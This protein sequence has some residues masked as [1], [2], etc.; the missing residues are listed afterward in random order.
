MPTDDGL[1]RAILGGLASVVEPRPDLEVWE[2]AEGRIVLG[3][4][5]TPWPGPL[6]FSRSPYMIGE[7]SPLWAY[8]RYEQIDNIWATQ[9]GKTLMLQVTVRYDA[10]CDPGPG[11]IVYP[12]QKVGQR[13]S[14]KHIRPFLEDASHLMTGVRDDMQNFEYRLTTCDI[15]IAW[16]GS[17]AVLAAEPI[18]H[19][20][21]DEEAKFD[22]GDDREAD[23]KSLALRRLMAYRPF[24]NSFGCTTPARATDPGWRDWEHSTQC[25]RWVPCP[26]CGA[27]QVVY[28][29][30]ED[31]GWL[32]PENRQAEFRGG[33]RWN[34]DEGLSFDDRCE[35]AYV[36]CRECGGRWDNSQLNAADDAGEWRPRRP[37]ARNYASHLPSWY[38]RTVKLADVVGRWLLG[39]RDP[40][41]RQD[42]DNSDRAIPWE[43]PSLKI[44][45]SVLER[46]KLPGHRRGIVPPAADV[47]LLTAD[48]MDDH[49]R[50]RVR[51]WNADTT[52]WGV[53][54][55]ALPPDLA[56]LHGVMARRYPRGDGMIGI[57]RGL[58]D[59]RWRTDE[60]EQYCLASG[61][62]C[63]PAMGHDNLREIWRPRKVVVVPNVEKGLLLGGELSRIDYLDDRWK[64]MMLQR[65]A[66]SFG[67]PG[68]WYIE[69]DVTEEYLHQ[70]QGE[71]KRESKDKRGR[72]H[73]AWNT[74]HANH[75]WDCEKLQ[76]LAT[77]VFQL[78]SMKARPPPAQQRQVINPYTG[79]VVA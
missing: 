63:W 49:I 73:M 53:D 41:L 46:H 56:Q 40:K 3:H 20:K 11:M 78:T 15:V 79:R 13:R 7:W 45:S 60:V 32:E 42:F 25:Q 9:S 68:C 14:K 34:K 28:F 58:I 51:A 23:S 27:Y 47:L 44:E 24:C 57:A 22:E 52:S 38:S 72:T 39:Y 18:K 59:A 36:E 29:N 75:D 12:T 2:W 35:T 16:A 71:V 5:V 43:A 6:S 66:V 70:M 33:I 19:L 21:L 65:L 74:V 1:C 30:A 8:R 64:D 17:P 77:V 4:R 61:G 55:G 10:E 62:S 67:E 48:V 37:K 31:R 69:D 76:L 50:Y 54:G 26:H